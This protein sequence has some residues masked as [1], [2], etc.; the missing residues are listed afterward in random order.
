MSQRPSATPL[1][2][3]TL[4]RPTSGQPHSVFYLPSSIEATYTSSFFSI[5]PYIALSFVLYN[6]LFYVLY[7]PFFS[8]KTDLILRYSFTSSHIVY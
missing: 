2:R 4:P 1:A 5:L 7:V 8:M 3:D 6:L